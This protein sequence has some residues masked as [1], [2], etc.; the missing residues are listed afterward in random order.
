[1]ERWNPVDENTVVRVGDVT[2]TVRVFLRLGRIERT[3]DGGFITT[4]KYPH[5][6][7][8][9]P[10]ESSPKPPDVDP[11]SL[12]GLEMRGYRVMSGKTSDQDRVEIGGGFFR[13][14]EA[15]KHGLI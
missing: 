11:Y 2:C 15:R 14:T 10:T 5:V 12:R 1:M 9:V 8:E 13:I 4:G 7:L 6:P 3:A